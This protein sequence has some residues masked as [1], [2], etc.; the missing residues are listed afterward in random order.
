MCL[1]AVPSIALHSLTFHYLLPFFLKMILSELLLSKRLSPLL[2]KKGFYLSKEAPLLRKLPHEFQL[3]REVKWGEHWILLGLYR[4]EPGGRRFEMQ[5]TKQGMPSDIRG[6]QK[7]EEEI[8]NT[9]C[10]V[11]QIVN[12]IT[13]SSVSTMVAVRVKLPITM[14]ECDWWLVRM[15]LYKLILIS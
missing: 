2:L 4:T 14:I 3:E 8:I 1:Q 6:R 12:S 9:R 13:L 10:E 5:R 15:W 11:C 7:E